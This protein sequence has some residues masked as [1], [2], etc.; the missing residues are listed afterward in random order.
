MPG[1]PA[2]L[3]VQASPWED[4]CMKTLGTTSQRC[5]TDSSTEVEEF[6]EDIHLAPV[7][8]GSVVVYLKY[9]IFINTEIIL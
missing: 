2:G 1:N 5:H 4:P 8:S 6:M 3:R 7:N 9:V